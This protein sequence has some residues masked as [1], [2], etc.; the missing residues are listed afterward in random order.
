MIANSYMEVMSLKE[1]KCKKML[2]IL[3]IFLFAIIIISLFVVEK[4]ESYTLLKSDKDYFLI[5]NNNCKAIKKNTMFIYGNKKVKYNLISVEDNVY[6]VNIKD[7]LNVSNYV[8]VGIKDKKSNVISYLISI[9]KK[10]GV[11]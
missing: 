11:S 1:I 7:K 9:L 8:S 5:C 2:Y 6:M 10:K 4:Y 3:V